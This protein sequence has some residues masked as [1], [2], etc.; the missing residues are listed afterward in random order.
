MKD[1]KIELTA[2]L[3][4]KVEDSKKATV[5]V[6]Y[7]EDEPIQPSASDLQRLYQCPTRTQQYKDDDTGIYVRGIGLDG[8][9]GSI[10][11]VHLTQG[12][13]CRWLRAKSEDSD[14][15][16][17]NVVLALCNYAQVLESNVQKGMQKNK[18]DELY[19]LNVLFRLI[20]QPPLTD[21]EALQKVMQKW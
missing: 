6:D 21:D 8:K 13:L 12:S 17:L 16:V 20:H 10:D 19:V 18:D 2:L 14:V 15:Y 11:I 7:G 1:I 4:T 3:G 9:W 5:L